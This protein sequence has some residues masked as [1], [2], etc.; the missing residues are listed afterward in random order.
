VAAT[1]LAVLGQDP[2]FGG[3]G[4]AQTEA[5]CAAARDL[6][7]DPLLLSRP[8]PVLHGIRFSRHRVEALRQLAAARELAPAAR[9]ARSLCVL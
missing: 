2:Q 6:G 3:G 5:F 8:H 9:E 7:R 4:V 1:D